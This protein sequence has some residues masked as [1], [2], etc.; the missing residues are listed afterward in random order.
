MPFLA[1]V[2]TSLSNCL[3]VLQSHFMFI[4]QRMPQVGIVD[5]ESI[6]SMTNHCYSISRKT[7]VVANCNSSMEATTMKACRQEEKDVAPEVASPGLKTWTTSEGAAEGALDSFPAGIYNSKLGASEEGSEIGDTVGFV[8][9][10]ELG[11]AIGMELGFAVGTE[12]GFAIGM[13]LGFAIGTELGFTVAG[14]A[15]GRG[16]AA[17]VGALSVAAIGALVGG[18]IGLEIMSL[19]VHEIPVSYSKVVHPMGGLHPSSHSDICKT[20]VS[21]AQAKASNCRALSENGLFHLWQGCAERAS[22]TLEPGHRRKRS[23]S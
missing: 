11:F 17:K 16:V 3:L 19:C 5:Y 15:V 2:D 1:L 4:T 18:D 9:G 7:L 14:V 21:F 23:I 22:S 10:T 13:E 8:I 20:L 6:V 12:L